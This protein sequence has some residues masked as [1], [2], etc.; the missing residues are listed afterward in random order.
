M[1]VRV[2]TT[3]RGTIN[4]VLE[5]VHLA[6]PQD[7]L[8]V[9]SL[10]EATGDA[11]DIVHVHWPEELLGSDNSPRSRAKRARWLWWLRARRRSGAKVIWTGHNLVPHAWHG[12]TDGWARVLEPFGQLVDG[13][14]LLSESSRPALRTVAPFLDDVPTI[15]IAHP[16]YRE[17][18]G[19]VAPNT[20]RAVRRLLTVG[21]VEPY[22][23]LPEAMTAA[24]GAGLDLTV[25][26]QIAPDLDA[27]VRQLASDTSTS[28]VGVTP[29]AALPALAANHDAW[30]VPQPDFLHSGSVLLGLSCN[31]PVVVA[32]TPVMRELRDMVGPDWLRLLPGPLDPETLTT[33]TTEPAPAGRPDLDAFDPATCSRRQLDFYRAL[34]TA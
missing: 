34:L 15:V 16:H 18:L 2:A 30:L 25:A 10:R 20:A 32:D 24:A 26:G 8:E 29:D 17:Q 33:A 21:R 31:L 1:K 11:D 13:V 23:H 4:P 28:L 3:L 5:N 12:T 19:A 27:T 14:V 9:R 22:K 7:D 6:W